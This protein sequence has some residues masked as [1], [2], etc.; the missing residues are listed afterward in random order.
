M[1]SIP[2]AGPT[3]GPSVPAPATAFPLQG[4]VPVQGP[5][6]TADAAARSVRT[7]RDLP[8]DPPFGPVPPMREARRNPLRRV[9]G[10]P[11]PAGPPGDG[12]GGI[13]PTQIALAVGGVLVLL[14]IGV[15]LALWLLGDD[16]PDQDVASPLPTATDEEGDPFGELTPSPNN[17]PDQPDAP[18]DGSEAPA[19]P[20]DPQD[21]DPADPQ[22]A[23]DAPDD[24]ATPDTPSEAPAPGTAPGGDDPSGE[25][26][27]GPGEG[28][29]EPPDAD[30]PQDEGDLDP[31][32]Q[33]P[34][35]GQQAPGQPAP[36]QQGPD[37]EDGQVDLARLFDLSQL[38]GGTAEE[39]TTV[40]Q[41]SR[42]DEA[43]QVEQLTGLSHPEGPI[44]VSAL[45]V[46][47]AP[48][49]LDALL[50]GA[51]AREVT[52]PG[53]T[54]GTGYVLEGQR[55]VWLVEGDPGTLLSVDGPATI[56]TDDL[57][58]IA[59]GLELLR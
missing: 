8:P 24:P 41:T 21:T 46:D 52:V 37:P 25:G 49:R 51:E 30:Q 47:D 12:D 20:A 50:D 15:G 29:L 19:D 55:L 22:D 23:P 59:N 42:D 35:P 45:R 33:A 28:T 1:S 27:D 53:A 18:E 10:T 57:L 26:G 2:P 34:A 43:T 54:D 3:P 11:A 56:G 39:D 38:P 17:P 36:P 32:T 6:P 7:W 58:T 14:A 13:T 31:P 44:E 48:A 9:G 4:P 16:E 5:P 40:T